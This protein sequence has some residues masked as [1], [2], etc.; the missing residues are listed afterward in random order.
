MV[1]LVIIVLQ[2]F[3]KGFI[4]TSAILIG[5]IVGYILSI[6]MGMVDFTAVKEASWIS[7]LNHLLWDLNLG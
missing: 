1:I 6:V 2:N 7:Y 3:T 5:I 4:K